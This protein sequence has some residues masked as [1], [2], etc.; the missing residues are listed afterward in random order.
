MLDKNNQNP[1][2]FEDP[3]TP[4]PELIVDL[5]LDKI[6]IVL[7]T[8]KSNGEEIS[9]DPLMAY[10]VLACYGG[11]ERLSPDII[12]KGD[13]PLV[14]RLRQI[15]SQHGE[16]LVELALKVPNAAAWLL[17]AD[18]FS[19]L[20]ED[21]EILEY[22]ERSRLAR[23]LLSDLDDADLVLYSAEKLGLGDEELDLELNECGSWVADNAFYLL[24]ATFFAQ[25]ILKTFRDDLEDQDPD[26]ALTKYK[27]VN[28]ADVEEM[29]MAELESVAE[30]LF[31][32]EVAKTI[33]RRTL[34]D[35]IEQPDTKEYPALQDPTE[36]PQPPQQQ[37][38]QLGEATINHLRSLFSQLGEIIKSNA[39]I[40][41]SL[42]PSPVSLVP[43][44]VYSYGRRGEEM[45]GDLEEDA[46]VEG[47]ERPKL[48]RRFFA[49]D[50]TW[51]A[52]LRL[53]IPELANDDSI[54]T[55]I[56]YRVKKK[57]VS[58]AF[59]GAERDVEPISGTSMYKAT[60]TVGELKDVWGSKDFPTI[61]IKDEDEIWTIGVLTPQD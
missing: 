22:H 39:R 11:I 30:P 23:E 37:Q 7:E 12:S 55:L 21:G 42:L 61:A 50:K 49:I 51:E 48:L 24:P 14:D 10:D 58:V 45:L 31:N 43:I 16:T 19:I 13:A 20:C 35:E 44:P 56:I 36:A 18:N 41:E 15:V 47:E 27:F 6:Y 53:P 25:T 5:L 4:G 28:V 46:D 26:L 33:I 9:P 54:V 17:E 8:W 34:G 52:Q 2:S 60:I 32:P 29:A 57:I 59:C 38:P 1:L 40:L 3:A